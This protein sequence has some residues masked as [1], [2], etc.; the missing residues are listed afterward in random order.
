[1]GKARRTEADVCDQFCSAAE[2]DGWIVYPEIAGWDLVLVWSGDHP[3]WRFAPEIEPGTQ[4]GVEAKLRANVD[5]LAQAHGR[6]RSVGPDYRAILAPKVG[7]SF[8]YVAHSL[9]VAT[10]SLAANVPDY[11]EPSDDDYV[12]RSRNDRR[13]PVI[14][15]PQSFNWEPKKRLDLPPIVPSFS[16]GAASPQSLSPWR[17]KALRMMTRLRAGE[18]VSVRD[19]NA[20]RLDHRIWVHNAWIVRSGLGS[21]RRYL[22]RLGPEP[23]SPHPDIGYEA[24]RTALEALDAAPE[25]ERRSGS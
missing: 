22:Y 19:F 13:M 25:P 3:R 12:A 24:E 14:A 9:K 8:R 7:Q 20:L 1:M 2:S 11:D 21:D 23:V 17:V 6:R 4:I 10:Y 16:G 5:V 18:E 15:P